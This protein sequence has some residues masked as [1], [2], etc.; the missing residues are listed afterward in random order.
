MLNDKE[1]LILMLEAMHD[2]NQYKNIVIK[3][4][5]SGVN[6]NKVVEI[7]RLAK[8]LRREAFKKQGK[9][10]IKWGVLAF[11]LGFFLSIA[12]YSAKGGYYFVFAGLLATGFVYSVIGVIQYYTGWN[13]Q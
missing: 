9:E 11:T 2:K 12:T 4:I 13:I 8:S 6:I 7:S 3:L 1:M 10:R 5:E